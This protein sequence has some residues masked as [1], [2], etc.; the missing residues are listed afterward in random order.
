MSWV[1]AL[2]SCS[3]TQPWFLHVSL[4]LPKCMSH[5]RE[6]KVDRHCL[7]FQILPL[8][9][10]PVLSILQ[11]PAIKSAPT[12]NGTIRCHLLLNRKCFFKN[13][14]IVWRIQPFSYNSARHLLVHGI[15]FLESNLETSIKIKSNS[16]FRSLGYGNTCKNIPNTYLLKVFPPH[17]NFLLLKIFK[18]TEAYCERLKMDTN[19]FIVFLLR[20]WVA[21]PVL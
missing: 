3:P 1:G 19:R 8:K 13:Y 9:T 6:I 5:G 11:K 20:Q 21:F 17:H 2:K 12:F 7:S 10:T 16:M 14:H 18:T 4:K 15:L